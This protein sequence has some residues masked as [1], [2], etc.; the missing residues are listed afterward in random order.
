MARGVGQVDAMTT[1]SIDI[2]DAVDTHLEAYGEP[3]RARR[4]G[5]LERVWSEDARLVDPP[6]VGAG[7]Q[8]ISALADG[9]QQQFAGHRF[10]RTSAVDTH[11]DVFRYSW[12]LVSPDGTAV[13]SGLDVGRLGADGRLR[14]IIGF[15]GDLGRT[16]A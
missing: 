4:A 2:S 16:D 5:L 12:E 14:E 6:A 9:L 11:N 8:G 1:T 7:R 3:D 10:R 13:L 15:F